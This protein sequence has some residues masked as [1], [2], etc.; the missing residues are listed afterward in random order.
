MKIYISGAISNDPNYKD[1]FDAAE[2]GLIAE[3]HLIVNPAKN[4]AGDYAE[5]V[6]IGLFELMRCD[7][8]YMLPDWRTSVG[9]RL[10]LHYATATGKIVLFALAEKQTGTN[11]DC[12]G[13][14][15]G[16]NEQYIAILNDTFC[17]ECI[18]ASGYVNGGTTQEDF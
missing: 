9:A 8:I 16:N 18:A 6:D 3:G 13:R 15:I 12:C 1:K 4:N 11:C 2:K 14:P 5:Y 7:A 17:A 10:E